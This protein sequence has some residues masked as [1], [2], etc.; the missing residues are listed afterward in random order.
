MKII[1]QQH[2]NESEE[3]L[4]LNKNDNEIRNKKLKEQKLNQIT[5][6]NKKEFTT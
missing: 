5:G 1:T 4:D 6:G 2:H 3:Y